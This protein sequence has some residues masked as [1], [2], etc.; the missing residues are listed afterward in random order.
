MLHSIRPPS[1]VD[2]SIFV[3][4]DTFSVFFVIFPVS[5]VRADFSQR[6]FC[7]WIFRRFFEGHFANALFQVLF[8]VSLIHA[9]VGVGVD[10]LSFS[11]LV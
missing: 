11:D 1:T 3:G 4:E 10:A 5:I 6:T 9:A 7:I 2:V 8:P